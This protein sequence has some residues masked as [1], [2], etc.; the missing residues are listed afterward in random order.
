MKVAVRIR[1][2][3]VVND[4]VYTLNIDTTPENVRRNQ[5]A[6]LKR[7]ERRVAINA[8]RCKGQFPS[9]YEEA[10]YANRSS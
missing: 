1:W 10:A 6:L 7:L 9:T 5:N 4:D 8:V 2:A 3:I